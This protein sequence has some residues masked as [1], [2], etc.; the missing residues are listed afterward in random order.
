MIEVGNRDHKKRAAENETQELVLREL[1]SALPSDRKLSGSNYDIEYFLRKERSQKQYTVPSTGA[2]LTYKQSLVCLATFAS[3][4]SLESAASPSYF[5]V[6]ALGGFQC[7]VMMPPGSPIKSAVGNVHSSKA[8][9]KC[10][11][12]F[13]M[14][15]QLLKGKYLDAHLQPT[16]RK[17]VHAM[18]NARLA[19]SSKKTSEYHMRSQPEIWSTLGEPAELFATVLTLSRP[20]AMRWP[21]TPLLLLTRKPLPRLAS[22]PLFFGTRRSSGVQCT[23]VAASMKVNPDAMTGLTMFTLKIFQDIF[24]KEYD[25]KD[26]ISKFPYFLAPASKPHDFDFSTTRDVNEII[27]WSTVEKVQRHQRAEYS[28]DESDDFFHDKFVTDP[29]DGSRKFYLRGRRRDLKARDPVPDGIVAPSHRAWKTSS[30]THDIINYSVS[31]WSKARAKYVWREDQ[32][33]VEAEL[34]S[35]RRN[36]LDDSITDEDLMPKPCFLVLQPMDISPVSIDQPS[37][38][39]LS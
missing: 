33:V 9:A 6:P 34:L 30:I 3:S 4:L 19:V 32:A 38:C 18:R 24:S 13:E 39:R 29:W 28:F 16:F 11:A 20:D 36:L 31:L 26:A 10:A 25:P 2:R 1:C 27:D 35:V 37:R 15:L 21:S 5:T 7:E 14:C 23:L 8:V 17:R 22:F 12:A